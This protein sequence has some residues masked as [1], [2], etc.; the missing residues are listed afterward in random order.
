M[1][2]FDVYDKETKN[3]NKLKKNQI[4][5]YIHAFIGTFI[6]VNLNKT[7]VSD[8]NWEPLFWHFCQ[9]GYFILR[10]KKNE[11]ISDNSGANKKN[12]KIKHT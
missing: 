4:K 7:K 12:G 6:T 10:W 3:V 11:T 2:I 9:F 5:F 8:K 1:G